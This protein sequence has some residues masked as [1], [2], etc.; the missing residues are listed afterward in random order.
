[1]MES[2]SLEEEHIIKDIRNLSRLIK[3]L[4]YTA[5][6]DIRNLFRLEKEIKQLKINLFEYKKEDYNKPVIVNNFGINNYIEY[7]SKV[8]K[9]YQLKNILTKLNYT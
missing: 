4:N 1:M 7:K 3:E 5:I 9:H 6:K 8:E 2:W